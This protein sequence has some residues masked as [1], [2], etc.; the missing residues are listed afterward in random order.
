MKLFLIESAG[1]I[2]K[3]K[4]ILGSEWNIKATMGH[5]VELAHDGEDSL[6]FTVDAEHNRIE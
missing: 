4:S 6:G 5:I 1:K 2:K 3:L